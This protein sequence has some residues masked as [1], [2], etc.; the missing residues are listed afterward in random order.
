MPYQRSR[1]FDY[2][3]HGDAVQNIAAPTRDT[4]AEAEPEA[5]ANDG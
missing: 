2:W 1:S 5:N 4:E 3:A